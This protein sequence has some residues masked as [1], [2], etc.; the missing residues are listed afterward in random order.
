MGTGTP[1]TSRY[2]AQLFGPFQVLRD[3]LA[4]GPA[5]APG[6][7]AARTL[8]KWFLLHPGTPWSPAELTELGSSGST[9]PPRLHRTLHYLRDYLEPERGRRDSTFIRRQPGG[10]V[11]DPADRWEVDVWQVHAMVGAAGQARD[12]GD[13]EQA[14]E[15]LEEIKRLD[16]R[17]FLPGDLYDPTFADIRTALEATGQKAQRLLLGLY[18][19]TGRLS[20]ALAHGLE[21]READPY[22]E[23]AARAVA[24][25]HARG[26]NKVA[27]LRVL[28]EFSER[29]EA[30]LGVSP[31]PELVDLLNHLRRCATQPVRPPAPVSDRVRRTPRGRGRGSG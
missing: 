16:A 1:E 27:G 10:Y 21:M 15:I 31:T 26:G 24:L 23:Q 7:T 4:L 25:A 22:D 9:P 6:L 8:L 11:F 2:R 28:I 19:D 12:R 13:P 29:L 17:T 20:L 3:D 14:I 30:E 18:V 5:G